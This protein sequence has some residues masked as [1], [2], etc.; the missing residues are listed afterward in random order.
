ML[1]AVKGNKQLKIDEA[2]KTTYLNMGY[3]IAEVSGD[4]L[5]VIAVPPSKSVPYAEY[6][7][8]EDENETLKDEIAALQEQLAETG[9]KTKGDK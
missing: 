2:E 8:L 5:D 9:K 6:K 4:R 1:Y 7:K 3:D